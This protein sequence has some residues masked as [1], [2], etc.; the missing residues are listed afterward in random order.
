MVQAPGVHVQDDR[1]AFL[2]QGDGPADGGLGSHVADAVEGLRWWMAW[3]EQLEHADHVVVHRRPAS[4][5]AT[6]FGNVE[7][8]NSPLVLHHL[9]PRPRICASLPHL[10]CL[11]KLPL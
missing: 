1:I 8:S 7:R 3:L 10:Q 9:S 4:E 6:E 5:E 2:D 11:R